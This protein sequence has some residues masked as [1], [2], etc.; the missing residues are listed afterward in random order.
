M[1]KR[2]AATCSTMPDARPDICRSI[3]VVPDPPTEDLVPRSAARNTVSWL[4]PGGWSARGIDRARTKHVNNPPPR[5][6]SSRG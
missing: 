3:V 1:T 4:D 6:R 5:T 2:H